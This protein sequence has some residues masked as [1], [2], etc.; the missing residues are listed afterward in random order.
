VGYRPERIR[1]AKGQE[2]EANED[3]RVCDY[4]GSDYQVRFWGEGGRDYEDRVER[5]AMRRLLP[6]AGERV[7][8]IGA[9]FGRLTDMLVGF[10]Q[11]VL[12]DYSRSLLREARERLGD[13]ER[14]LYVAADA[15][16]LPFAPGVFDAAT[17]V[18]V[19]HHMADTPAVLAQVRGVMRQDAVFVLEF[20]NKLNLKAIARWLARRQ[21][22]NPFDREPVEFVELNFDFHPASMQARLREARFSPGRRLTVS[23]FRVEL[24]KRMVPTG[25]LAWMDGVAQW[26]GD[27]WQL[28]PSVFVRS[29]AVGSDPDTPEGAFWRCPVCGCLTLHDHQE[30]LQ[31]A[32]CGRK[33]VI[34]DGI[35]DFKEPME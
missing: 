32:D 34:R 30:W 15:Y 14:Y 31:C 12:L 18:R 4:E 23:H 33:W 8:E 2:L 21:D 22:W 9:G 24:L 28:S 29:M 19:I 13:S 35:Y 17:M 3:P 1:L 6:P 25:L 5:I 10:R 16:H 26:T 7:L 20:A 27:L 11:V